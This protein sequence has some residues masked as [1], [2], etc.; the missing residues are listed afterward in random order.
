MIF[1]W[2]RLSGLWDSGVSECVRAG[3]ELLQDAFAQGGHVRRGR[4][5]LLY[6]TQQV[7]GAF[8]GGYP[9]GD[10][11][12][13]AVFQLQEAL[14]TATLAA[15]RAIFSGDLD[16]VEGVVDHRRVGDGAADAVGVTD[17]VQVQDVLDVYAA[18]G[19]DL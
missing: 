11:L 4:E 1:S 19:E 3:G 8:G 10:D 14:A 7:A 18:R 9:R 2:P 13:G 16:D 5:D 15:L 12:A 17:G 6:G